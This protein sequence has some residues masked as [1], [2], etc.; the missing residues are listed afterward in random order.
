MTSSPTTNTQLAAVRKAVDLLGGQRPA[1]KVIGCSQNKIWKVYNGKNVTDL[2]PDL[3]KALSEA[4]KG[5]V[6]KSDMLP[7]IFPPRKRKAVL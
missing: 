2:K 3:V 6:K 7:S 5:K 4:V 1:A